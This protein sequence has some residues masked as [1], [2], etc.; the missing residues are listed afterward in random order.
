MVWQADQFAKEP[1]L[2][3]KAADVYRQVNA[4]F[5]QTH[6]AQVARQRLAKIEA[7]KEG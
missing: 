6:W 3:Q 1:D 5:P 2:T 7:R 4:S